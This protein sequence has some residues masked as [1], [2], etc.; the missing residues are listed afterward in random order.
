MCVYLQ[1]H[2]VPIDITVAGKRD[3]SAPENVGLC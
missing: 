2:L 1:K 3:F